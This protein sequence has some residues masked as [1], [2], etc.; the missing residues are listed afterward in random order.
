ME[1]ADCNEMYS[2]THLFMVF[3]EPFP[4]S[5]CSSLMPPSGQ[6]FRSYFIIQPA[7]MEETQCFF[8]YDEPVI[9]CNA[10]CLSDDT[11]LW[12]ITA[13]ID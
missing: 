11:A 10:S 4:L 13:K 3:R 9:V 1:W 2:F 6:H 7:D 5:L 12:V 8:D